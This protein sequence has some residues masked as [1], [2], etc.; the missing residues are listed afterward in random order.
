MLSLLLTLSVVWT[1]AD[2]PPRKPSAIAPSLPELTREEERR[3]DDII[4]R[5]TL[6]DTG[7]LVG[8][9]ARQAVKE[10]ESLQ[11][12]AIPALIRGLNRAATLNHSCPVLMISKKL[13]KLLLASEDEQLLEYARDEIGAGIGPTRHAGVLQDLRVRLL[14]RKNE[15]ARRPPIPAEGPGKLATFQLIRALP[16]IRGEQLRDTLNELARREEPQALT[17]ILQAARSNDPERAQLARDALDRHLSAQSLS[18]VKQALD[19]NRSEL[20]RSAIRVAIDKHTELVLNIIDRLTDKES[21]VRL[22]AHTALKKL[23]KDEVDFGPTPDASPAQREKARQA[24]RVWW[25][26][27]ISQDK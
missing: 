23:S 14:L 8:P 17:A 27:K 3:L 2:N 5:F 25:L 19:D 15:L 11:A 6:A 4:D 13:L 22:E 9:E 21:A 24:W 10:F 1:G 12:E 26:K 18:G 16:R 20:R 7:K